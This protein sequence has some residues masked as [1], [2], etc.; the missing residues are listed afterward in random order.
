VPFAVD[1]SVDLAHLFAVELGLLLPA[2][3]VLGLAGEPTKPE[4]KA[5]LARLLEQGVRPVEPHYTALYRHLEEQAGEAGPAGLLVVTVA[6]HGFSD[7]GADFLL[8]SDSLRERVVRT[9]LAVDELFETVARAASPRRLVLLD[10]CRERLS[11][12]T[13]AAAGSPTA[14]S[15]AAAIARASGQVVLAAATLGGY[16]YDDRSQGN[17]AFTAAVLEGRRGAAPAD[18]R[19]FITAGTLADFVQERVAAWV[20]RHWPE[21]AGISR[22]ISRRVE[23]EAQ[24]LPLAVNPEQVR[25]AA[26]YRARREAAVTKLWQ[27]RGEVLPGALCDQIEKMLPAE[28]P[29]PGGA[30]PDTAAGPIE[31]L[32]AEIE[33]LDGGPRS[34]RSLRDFVRELQAKE[35]SATAA[36]PGH[37]NPPPAPRAPARPRPPPAPAPPASEKRL[38]AKRAAGRSVLRRHA[39]KLA[40]AAAAAAGLTLVLVVLFR[41]AGENGGDSLTEQVGMQQDQPGEDAAEQAGGLGR[42]EAAVEQQRAPKQGGQSGGE[43]EPAALSGPRPPDAP[44]STATGSPRPSTLSELLRGESAPDSTASTPTRQPGPSTLADLLRADPAA[45]TV[46][47]GA[48]GMRLRFIPGGRYLIGSPP[49]EPGRDGDET[50]HPVRITRGFWLAETEVT[51]GQWSRLVPRNPS[52]FSA[53]GEDCPVEQVS[54]YEAVNFANLVSQQA[55]L[56]PCYQTSGATGTLGEETYRFETVD[57]TGLDCPGYRLPTEA[58]WEVAARAG[59]DTA[60]YTGPLTLKGA[61]HAP[62]LDLIAWYGGNSGVAYTGGVDCSGWPQKQFSA[63]R[64]GTHAV[65]GKRANAWGL[66]DMLGNVREWTWDRY[67]AYPS[68]EAVDPLGAAEGSARVVRGGSWNGVARAVRAAYRSR[69]A[70]SDRWY[71]LGFRLARGQVRQ[72]E[73]RSP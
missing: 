28:W 70:P 63:Q 8:A 55:G 18:P 22:G 66:H 67:G 71:G 60:I 21:H 1:D 2:R 37:P 7:Q 9:G 69:S 57:P 54:W 13:R 40:L 61:H 24:S 49:D 20:A 11:E 25:A 72:G 17:G 44:P 15:F 19:G 50:R 68:G 62:E 56:P 6:S 27:N 12:D 38:Q 36:R 32:L 46:L 41:S 64:C 33:A 29:R 42:D 30:A 34:Q 47:E 73:G 53:C 26:A 5:R 45:C 31:D 52:Y 10:A 3:C 39:A 48:L 43:T 35:E 23:G 16:A 65:A 14:A 51:Q 59:S 4:T 58:E